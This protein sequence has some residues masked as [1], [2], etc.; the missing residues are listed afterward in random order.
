MLR[1]VA[2]VRTDVSEELSASGKLSLV[3]KTE[4][5]A[6]KLILSSGTYFPNRIILSIQLCNFVIRV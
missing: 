3:I 1:R 2:L 4:H 5:I 6:A